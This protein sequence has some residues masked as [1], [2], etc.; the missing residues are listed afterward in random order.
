MVV[1]VPSALPACHR[2]I[3][4]SNHRT[5]VISI[6]IHFCDPSLGYRFIGFSIAI[7]SVFFRLTPV[8]LLVVCFT[9]A[10]RTLLEFVPVERNRWDP[11]TP[12]M[13]L[14]PHIHMNT[15][16]NRNQKSNPIP[17]PNLNPNALYAHN[18]IRSSQLLQF[19]QVYM[20]GRNLECLELHLDPQQSKQEFQLL[21]PFLLS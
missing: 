18:H 5:I 13:Q 9:I 11:C 21:L 2:S 17:N 3:N 19:F 6:A 16:P 1:P 7:V 20:M 14:C 4:P 10:I 12:T 15:H 8:G